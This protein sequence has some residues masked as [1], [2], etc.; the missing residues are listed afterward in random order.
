MPR[1][2]SFLH[3]PPRGQAGLYP[4]PGPCSD[5][6][7]TPWALPGSAAGIRVTAWSKPARQQV[8][9]SE[10]LPR[11]A[12]WSLSRLALAGDPGWPRAGG[13]RSGQQR[14]LLCAVS[15]ELPFCPH[16]RLC[17]RRSPGWTGGSGLCPSL[18]SDGLVLPP[19]TRSRRPRLPEYLC[20]RGPGSTLG[21]LLCPG[22]FVPCLPWL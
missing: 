8:H 14:D 21:A 19:P 12:D 7:H 9:A 20:Q 1:S 18:S 13:C 11:W 2:G 4:C 10:R 16:A 15:V 17:R 6:G 3:S 22:V 5:S